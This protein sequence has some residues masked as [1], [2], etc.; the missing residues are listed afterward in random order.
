MQ[1]I[2]VQSV[3]G[4]MADLGVSSP[5]LDQA[6][7]GFSFMQDGPLDMRMDNSKGLTAAEWLLEIEEEQL[8]NIIYQYGEERYSR[9]IAKAIKQAG[10]LDTTAQLAELVKTVIQNGKSISIQLRVLFRQSVLLLT[11]TG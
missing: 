4:I 7:R 1:E 2:G 10:K 6:E 9:R 11:R 5:Q 8:A 3:D